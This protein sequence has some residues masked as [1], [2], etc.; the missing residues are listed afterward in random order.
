MK[1][2][3]IV[4]AGPSGLFTAYELITKNNEVLIYCYYNSKLGYLDK[5]SLNA[6]VVPPVKDLINIAPSNP[7]TSEKED[8]K[9]TTTPSS[10]VENLQIII[11]VGISVISISV[12]YFLFKP[13]KNKIETQIDTPSEYYEE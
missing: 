13:T 7:D 3:I 4:G 12:V 5:N 6:Y 2:V 8:N 9:I 10:S 1:N 11:I